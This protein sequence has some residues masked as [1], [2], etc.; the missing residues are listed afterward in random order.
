MNKP[1]LKH[2]KYFK[3]YP[4]QKK[5][6]LKKENRDKGNVSLNRERRLES[7]YGVLKGKLKDSLI[8]KIK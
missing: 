2:S 4:K 5:L 8:N 7:M 6:V 3:I 1:L